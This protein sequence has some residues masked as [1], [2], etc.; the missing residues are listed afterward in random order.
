MRA[1]SYSDSMRFWV[2]SVLKRSI[3]DFNSLSKFSKRSS[4]C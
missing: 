4:W 1:R 2:R 3:M